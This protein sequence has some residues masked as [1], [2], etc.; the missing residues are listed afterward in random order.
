MKNFTLLLFAVLLV[1]GAQ[2]QIVDNDFSAWEDNLPAGWMGS[3]SNIGAEN[4]LQADNDGGQGDYAVELVN[5]TTSH[6]RLTSAQQTVEAGQNYE[7]T[8]WAR[9]TGDLRTGLFDDREE[10]FGFIY[11]PYV[12]VSSGDWTEYSQNIIAQEN[13]NIAEFIFSVQNTA[14]D[15]NIQ[16]DRVVIETAELTTVSIYDIQFTEA[17]DGASPLAGEV[18]TTEGIVTAASVGVGGYFLQNGGGAW[19]GLFVYSFDTPEIGDHV[20]VTGLVEEYN[21][22]TELTT[23]SG[24][25]ILSSGNSIETTNISTGQVNE[26]SFEGVLAKVWDATV[27]DGNIGNGQ[28]EINDGSGIAIV[29][30]DIYDYD[31]L[32]G[33]NYNIRGVVSY[34]YGDR[35]LMPRQ[36]NDVELA[37]GVDEI[38]DAD[39]ISIFPNPAND[40]LNL[41]WINGISGNVAYNL[42]NATGQLVTSGTVAQPM[43]TVDVSD[44]TPGLYTLNLDT[45]KGLMF[46]RVMIAR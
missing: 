19:N 25:T 27:T 9:G 18:V 2:S 31:A 17:P 36:P 46:T 5:A 15:L 26:E 41:N 30:P 11:S 32:A 40:V 16:I 13:T 23:T 29:D 21:S 4:V 6:K 3:K 1:G 10:G 45:E 24:F 14:G 33:Q 35:I 12:S 8:F 39:G 38:S 42:Y 7:I 37:T 43:G 28:Y 20:V 34:A 22:L 44:L